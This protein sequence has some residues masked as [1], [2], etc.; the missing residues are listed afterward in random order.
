[1]S[2]IDLLGGSYFARSA[3]AN[4]QRCINYFPEVNRQD[5]PSGFTYYQRP[6]LA[7]LVQAAGRGAVRGIYRAS[8]GQGFAVIGQGV[9]Y[10]SPDWTLTLLGSLIVPGNNPVSFIDNSID[11]MLVDGS[12]F[13]YTINLTTRAF[14]QI[15]DPTGSFTGATRVDYIDTFIIWNYLGT[16]NFGSTLSNSISFDALYIAAKTAYPDPL[17]VPV[18]NRHEIILLGELK[19]EIWYNSGGVQFPFA[20]L[21]GAYV[22]HGCGA[23]YSIAT[24]DIELFWLAQD[25]QGNRMVLCKKGY[26]T[27]RISNHALEFALSQIPDVSDAIGYTWQQNGHVMYSLVFPSGDQTWVYDVS[28][29]DRPEMA[30]HQEAFT[31]TEGDFH[32]TRANCG[33][34][35]YG[36]NVVGDYENGTIYA[37]DQTQYYDRVDGVDYRITCVKG[38]PHITQA[39][40]AQIGQMLGASG[41][42]IQLKLF[43]VDM[44]VGNVPADENGEAQKLSLRVSTTKGLS[45]Q[46]FPL[47]SAGSPGEYKTAPQW[48]VMGIARDFVLELSHSLNG[49]A[50]LNGGWVEADILNS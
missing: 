33:A 21:P 2:R 25:L 49:P 3:I 1:M 12:P 36:K 30:W 23:K 20:I 28:L 11:V 39:W 13:G 29:A 43:M 48:R 47:Q 18:V 8:D 16:K 5:S 6:G 32:R 41:H 4:A 34:F 31:P 44:E 38:F 17:V 26:D 37:L 19:S 9:Y 24:A 45:W 14:A 27:R 7:P 22:E 40:N 15:V 46:N 50:A 42:T 10:V 35:L